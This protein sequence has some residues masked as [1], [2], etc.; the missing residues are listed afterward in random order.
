M[1][2]NTRSDFARFKHMLSTP[3]FVDNVDNSVY[4]LFFRHVFRWL[5]MWITCGR[6]VYKIGPCGKKP[7][8]LCNFDKKRF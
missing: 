8:S 2:K 6:D 1:T 3:F 5:T 4:N 7:V